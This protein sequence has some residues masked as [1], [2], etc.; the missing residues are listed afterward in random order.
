VTRSDVD[1]VLD[2]FEA[3]NDR[4]F[5]RAMDHYADDVVLFVARAELAPE[6]GTYEGKAAVGEWFG[7][8]FRHFDRDYHFNIDEARELEDRTIFIHA[9][10]GGHGRTSGV[11]VQGELFYVYRVRDG[12]VARVEIYL[13]RAEALEAAGAAE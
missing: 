10:H 4:D 7:N 1:V 9:R 3:V 12:K 2:Q 6:P 13:T 11:E 5:S 8:W